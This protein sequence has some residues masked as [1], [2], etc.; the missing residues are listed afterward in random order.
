ML[1]DG[2][3]VDQHVESPVPRDGVVDHALGEGAVA[4]I[5][6]E[7]L[8]AR[9]VGPAF[10]DELA[11]QGLAPGDGHH[12]R[13]ALRERPGRDPADAGRRAGDDDDTTRLVRHGQSFCAPFRIQVRIAARSASVSGTAPGGMELPQKPPT[14][15]ASKLL[16]VPSSFRMNQLRSGSP[17]STRFMDGSAVLGTP[18]MT[19]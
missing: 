16:W 7:V 11:Q 14:H 2:G 19:E 13:A 6:G 1:R 8:R 18:T 12:R 17:G 5:A 3:V 10:G 9:R 15:W 4:E